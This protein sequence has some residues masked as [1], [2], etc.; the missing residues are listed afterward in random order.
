[1]QMPEQQYF[2]GETDKE[3]KVKVKFPS[4]NIQYFEGEKGKERKVKGTF[5]SG[6]VQYFEG[7]QGKE[8][9]VKEIFS[10]GRVCYFE[11]ERGKEYSLADR[12][13][14]DANADALI[15][16]EEEEKARASKRKNRKAS[17][18]KAGSKTIVLPV[19]DARDANIQVNPLPEPEALPEPQS[20][21]VK[22]ETSFGSPDV[23]SK[24][25][26]VDGQ[27]VICMDDKATHTMVPCGHFCAC[28]TCATRLNGKCPMCNAHVDMV[29]R[30]YAP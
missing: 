18:K 22:S 3:R 27:C 19:E 15:A 29:M 8:R 21:E 11:G 9:L 26:D 14:A 12:A 2:E 5:P 20:E 23:P 6:E 16:A 17:K 10:N 24:E 7:E 1:M 13:V 4:G 28:A 25:D 30:V